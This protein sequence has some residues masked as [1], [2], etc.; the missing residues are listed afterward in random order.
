MLPPQ[1]V[2]KSRKRTRRAHHALK[3][4]HYVRCAHCGNAK[5]PHAAC[6][7][8]GFVR[9]GLALKLDPLEGETAE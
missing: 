7:S 9:P 4:P 3:P 1:R 6:G 2:S 8:C 5:L